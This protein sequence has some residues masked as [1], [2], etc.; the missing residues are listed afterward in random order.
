[1]S[2]GSLTAGIALIAMG[3][4]ILTGGVTFTALGPA[5]LACVGL[6]LLGSGM[7]RRDGDRR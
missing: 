6:I 7:A 3:T 5:L 2:F 1:M 4:W